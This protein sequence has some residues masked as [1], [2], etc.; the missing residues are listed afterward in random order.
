MN[1]QDYWKEVEALAE[2]VWDESVEA[3]DGDHTAALDYLGDSIL[4][5]TIDGHEWIIYYGYNLDILKYS[6]NSDY[7]MDEL[8]PES[9]AITL[10]EK[11]LDGLH[12]Y[13]AYFAL[14]AD[15]LERIH[16]EFA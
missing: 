1:E 14:Y 12:Q 16:R 11:G 2:S 3:C 7:A 4:H 10:K 8:G 9:A 5:E 15:V 6:D 13:L